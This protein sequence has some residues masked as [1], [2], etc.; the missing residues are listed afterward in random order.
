MNTTKETIILRQLQKTNEMIHSYENTL[1]SWEKEYQSVVELLRVD[2]Q[3][4]MLSEIGMMQW[5]LEEEKYQQVILK[6]KLK[7]LIDDPE[8]GN[9]ATISVL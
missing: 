8:I 1:A 4:N 2:D 6:H 7:E 5:S 3:S 9:S